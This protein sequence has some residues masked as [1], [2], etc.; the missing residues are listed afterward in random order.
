MKADKYEDDD[1]IIAMYLKEINRIP[2]LS[3]EDEEK[4]AT[5]AAQGDKNA[6]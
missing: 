1:N 6:R 5:L 2:L 3:R 4:Y